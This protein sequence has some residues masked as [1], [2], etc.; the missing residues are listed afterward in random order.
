MH[1]DIVE[2]SDEAVGGGGG[3]CE[4][5]APEVPGEDGNGVCEGDSPNKA[6]SIFSPC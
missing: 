4:G 3:K 1:D 6:E 2:V 5:I